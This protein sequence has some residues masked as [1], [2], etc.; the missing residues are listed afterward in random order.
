MLGLAALVGCASPGPPRPPSLQ[1]PQLAKDIGVERQ[2]G[3]VLVRFTLPQRTIDDLPIRESTIVVT[4][5]RG[6]EAAACVPLRGLTDVSMAFDGSAN[7]ARRL[8]VWHDRLPQA[9]TAGTPRLLEYRVELKNAQGRSAGWSDR[10]Y[11]AAG[12][13]PARVVNLRA[14]ETRAG[15][16]LHWTLSG[17]DRD[18]DEVLLRREVVTPAAAAKPEQPV[19]LKS[20]AAG[21][22]DET[23]DSSADEN[24][25]YRYVA[26]R[27]RVEQIG[28][29]R[30]EVRSA[31]SGPVEI[32]WANRFPPPAPS[33]L[34][35]APFE[36]GGR[37]AIDLVWQ[38]LVEPGLKDYVV[39]RQ[40]LDA[41][42]KAVGEPE[43]L[44]TVEAPAFHDATAQAGV[45]YRYA[46]QGVSKNDVEG[47][48]ATVV[49]N[50]R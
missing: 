12:A 30:L 9:E 27:Q 28:A 20:N 38:P 5:C 33:G 32:T 40:P 6:G 41:G 49:V 2:G 45:S 13:A 19:W 48:S 43:R 29:Q 16:L 23:L 47:A 42:G 35:A 10:A 26:F 24:T 50:G 36:Q 14:E 34:S 11:T 25:P 22:A 21:D 3:D 39:T 8:V 18:G 4:V 7:P 1:L 44:G 17:A 46:V 15:I 37:F 31:P